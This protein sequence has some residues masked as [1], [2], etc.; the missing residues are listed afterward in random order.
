MDLDSSSNNNKG[1]RSKNDIIYPLSYPW[2]EDP[3]DFHA[4]K[5]EMDQITQEI[6]D[7]QTNIENGLNDMKTVYKTY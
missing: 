6:E 2:A 7:I 1:G 5:R 4:L 3:A